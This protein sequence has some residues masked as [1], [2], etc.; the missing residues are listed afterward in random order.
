VA[1]GRIC[2]LWIDWGIQD[3]ILAIGR[4][5]LFVGFG[6]PLYPLVN[7]C[8]TGALYDVRSE[9]IIH[10]WRPNSVRFVN[11]AKKVVRMW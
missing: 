8:R 3:E 1:I 6:L 10:C 11:E 9:R 7:R 4:P 2:P 5:L